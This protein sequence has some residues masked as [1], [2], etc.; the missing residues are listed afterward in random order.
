MGAPGHLCHF[1]PPNIIPGNWLERDG[2][3]VGWGRGEEAES[4]PH[5]RDPPVTLE[6]SEASGDPVSPNWEET[7]GTW[8]V[9]GP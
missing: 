7:H 5:R 3:V 6:C 2:G 8:H 4:A 1:G 9:S